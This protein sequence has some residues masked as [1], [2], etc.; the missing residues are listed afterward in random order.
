MLPPSLAGT[1][2]S[3]LLQAGDSPPIR[4]VEAVSGG[5]ANL[6]ARLTTDLRS[7]LLK[8]D[9][10]LRPGIFPT[11]AR[12]LDLLR[13]VGRMRV[14][15]VLAAVDPVGETPGFILEEWIE[16]QNVECYWRSG[17]RYGERLARFHQAGAAQSVPRYGVDHDNYVGN[18]PQS[19]TWHEDWVSF[20]RNQRLRPLV[21]LAARMELLSTQRRD[22]L[23]RLME[24]L[25]EWLGG[26]EREPVLLHGD[27]WRGNVLFDAGGEAVLIDPAV[28]WGDREFDLATVAIYEPAPDGFY[29]AYHS[30]WPIEPGFTERRDLHNLYLLLCCLTDGEEFGGRVDAVLNRYLG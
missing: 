1:I 12:G 4:A 8:W 30:V 7:Y 9:P 22:R 29:E 18:T 27:L 14:P 21:D 23:E 13:Q 11:E 3:T 26:V 2:E 20:Y 19:N 17:A 10:K 6:A 15:A 24:R 28:C 25:A 5:Y 16:P